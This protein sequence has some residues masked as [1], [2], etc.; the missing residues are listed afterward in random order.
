MSNWLATIFV[1][2]AILAAEGSDRRN[3]LSDQEIVAAR[4]MKKILRA[5]RCNNCWAGWIV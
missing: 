1:G 2:Q 4:S 5:L 3:R